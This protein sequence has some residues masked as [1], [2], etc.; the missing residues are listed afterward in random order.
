MRRQTQVRLGQ[1]S[2]RRSEPKAVRAGSQSA[3]C[4]K[5][6]DTWRQDL[7]SPKL[8][9]RIVTPLAPLPWRDPEGRDRETYGKANMRNQ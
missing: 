9:V 8:V 7:I 3:G 6:F 4:R 5:A 2:S 1:R